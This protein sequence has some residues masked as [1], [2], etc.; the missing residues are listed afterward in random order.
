MSTALV[1]F[2]DEATGRPMRSNPGDES[3]TSSVFGAVG[4]VFDCAFKG[5]AIIGGSFACGAVTGSAAR[6]GC[7]ESSDGAAGAGA[8]DVTGSGGGFG[9]GGRS[10]AGMES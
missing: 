1:I 6:K 3:T 5:G 8:G 7:A 2:A 10:A 4:E 9:R